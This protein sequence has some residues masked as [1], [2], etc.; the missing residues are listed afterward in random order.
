MHLPPINKYLHD[1]EELVVEWSARRNIN[2]LGLEIAQEK[3][4]REGEL[5][6][7]R[8]SLHPIIANA[9]MERMMVRSGMIG[10]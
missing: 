7:N 5:P 4:S 8:I 3:C 1:I 9:L 2:F 10:Q 6:D